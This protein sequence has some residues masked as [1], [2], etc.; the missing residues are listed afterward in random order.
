MHFQIWT[1]RTIWFHKGS[2]P[3]DDNDGK[4]LCLRLLLLLLTKDAASSCPQ[5]AAA[6]CNKRQRMARR[7]CALLCNLKSE[8]GD[9]LDRVS[10]K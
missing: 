3:S 5:R 9:E 4:V 6:S 8:K 2:H 10:D 7:D 1:I